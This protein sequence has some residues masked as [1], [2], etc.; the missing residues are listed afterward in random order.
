MLCRMRSACFRR[1]FWPLPAFLLALVWAAPQRAEAQPCTPS[2]P[3]QPGVRNGWQGADAAYSIPLAGRKSVWVFG[4]TLYGPERA[5]SGADPRM[6]HN[7]LALSDCLQGGRWSIRYLLREDEQGAPRSFFSP[8]DPAHWYWAM[9]GVRWRGRLW[10][11]LLCLRKPAHPAAPALNFESCGADLASLPLHGSPLEEPVQ[12]QPLTPSGA[13]AEPTS[14]LVIHGGFLYL[15]GVRGDGALVAGR[16]ALRRLGQAQ[17]GLQTLE[18]DGRWRRGFHPD[19]AR[20]LMDGGA[21]EMSIRYHPRW[22]RWAAV[23]KDPDLLSDRVLLRSARTLLGPWSRPR[24]L[25]HI[26][27]LDPAASLPGVFCYAGKEHP[28]LAA[29]RDLLVTYVCNSADPALLLREPS[30]YV[31]KAVR[32]RLGSAMRA[33]GPSSRP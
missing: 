1:L 8:A 11:S 31:P 22:K 33:P 10:L 28:E 19:R 32:L 23:Y 24:L 6:V 20:A 26:R 4:D 2:F 12:I 18:R 14:T 3:L 27:R 29:G 15:F 21:A 5:L 7:S 30:L 25:F 9:D 16:V 17:A 13:G